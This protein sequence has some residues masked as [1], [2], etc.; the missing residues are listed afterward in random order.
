MGA[1]CGIEH[2]MARLLELAYEAGRL[3]QR[4]L[5]RDRVRGPGTQIPVAAAVRGEQGRGPAQ[6]EDQIGIQP[7]PLLGHAGT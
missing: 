5:H 6:V 2:D 1:E 3:E 4:P 7:A